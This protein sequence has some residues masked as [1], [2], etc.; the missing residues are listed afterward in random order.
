MM[1]SLIKLAGLDGPVPAYT[2]LCRRQKTMLMVEL[3]GRSSS[4][5]LRLL[6]DSTR[7]KMT[8]EGEWKTRKHDVSNRRSGAR[9]I[10]DRRGNAGYR[11]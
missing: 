5:G 9:Y 3:G 2:A 11:P 7:I 8:G 6:V 4:G 1:A 10:W